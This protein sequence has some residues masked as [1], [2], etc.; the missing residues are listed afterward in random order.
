MNSGL[1]SR[2][3]FALVAA[4]VMVIGLALP[5][6][7]LAQF[8]APPA[9]PKK[10]VVKP[11]NALT[12]KAYRK[13][14]ARHLY[15]AYPKKIKRGKMPPMLYSVMVVETELDATGQVTAVNVVR[16]PAAEIV[17][18][19]VIAMIKKASPFPVPSKLTELP[20]RYTETWLVDKSGVFQ[21]DSLTEGQR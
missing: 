5:Q 12:E 18:P 16:K 19:W 15:T 11:S 10:L 21:L 14:A 9:L 8:A 13:D 1:L 6:T 4:M 7:A 2:Y 20:V 3:A 17:E